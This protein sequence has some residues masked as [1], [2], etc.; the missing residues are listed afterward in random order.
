MAAMGRLRIKRR[1]HQIKVKQGRRVK[2]AALRTKFQA[3]GAE[4][5]KKIVEKALKISPWL[6]EKEFIASATKTKT[7]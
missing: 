7:N 1:Q 3:A 4:G 2:L 5:K 6:S